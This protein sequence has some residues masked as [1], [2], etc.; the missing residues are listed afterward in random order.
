MMYSFHSNVVEKSDQRNY[1][2]E[3]SNDGLNET[4][5]AIFGVG[6]KLRTELHAVKR[7]ISRVIWYEVF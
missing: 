6:K 2:H 3:D 1:V 7:E 5:T 4:S